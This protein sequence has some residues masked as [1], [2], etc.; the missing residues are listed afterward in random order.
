MGGAANGV[1][2]SPWAGFQQDRGALG[3]AVA[4]VSKAFSARCRHPFEC[5]LLIRTVGVYP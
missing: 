3:A 2:N 1:S 5:D 4:D